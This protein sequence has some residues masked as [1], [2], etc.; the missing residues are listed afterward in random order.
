MI[1]VLRLLCIAVV[2]IGSATTSE[3]QIPIPV[4]D[5][6]DCGELGKDP[7]GASEARRS[8]DL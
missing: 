4:P 8:F 3:A 5:I 6:G 2:L 1:H 7:L